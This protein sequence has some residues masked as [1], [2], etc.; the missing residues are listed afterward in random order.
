MK[1]IRTI[2]ALAVVVA[3]LS[4]CTI[5]MPY[6]VTEHPIGEKKGVSK[7]TVLFGVIQFNGNYGIAE[8]AKKGKIKG[9]ISTVDLRTTSYLGAILFTKELLVTGDAE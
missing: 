9:P 5:T 1:K 3:S 7:T 8:A 2:L 4:S 6:A